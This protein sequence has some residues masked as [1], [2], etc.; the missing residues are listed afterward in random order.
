VAS[1]EVPAA[2]IIALIRFLEYR[3]SVRQAFDDA[4]CEQSVRDL[5]EKLI[6]A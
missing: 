2:Q 5:L 3:Y 4:E 6:H 1:P